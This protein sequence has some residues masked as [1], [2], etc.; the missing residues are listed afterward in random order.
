MSGQSC[1]T[2]Y[3]I[4]LVVYWG[5]LH[6]TLWITSDGGQSPWP[7]YLRGLLLI[8][9][10]HI[11]CSYPTEHSHSGQQSRQLLAFSADLIS[12]HTTMSE[13]AGVSPVGMM[14]LTGWE[15]HSALAQEDRSR[16]PGIGSTAPA[17]LTRALYIPRHDGSTPNLSIYDFGT[18]YTEAVGQCAIGS[19]RYILS[20]G[21][22]PKPHANG[23]ACVYNVGFTDVDS[24]A[25]GLK[26]ISV[27]PSSGQSLVEANVYAVSPPL[28]SIVADG[29]I[30]ALLRQLKTKRL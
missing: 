9:T 19:A 22:M 11:Y 16:R 6:C 2:L 12:S 29:S 21:Q 23:G 14:G 26:S 3:S 8:G 10:D 25:A 18:Q 27:A 15:T 5:R 28:V 30:T 17:H 20:L 7:N 1:L 4:R 24:D 13:A